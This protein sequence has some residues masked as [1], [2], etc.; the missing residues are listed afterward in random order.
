MCAKIN[1]LTI[2]WLL[3]RKKRFKKRFDDKIRKYRI[4]WQNEKFRGKKQF[5]EKK[6]ISQ[7]GKMKKE[8]GNDLTK[9]ETVMWPISLLRGRGEKRF[10]EK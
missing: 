6:K 5:D 8:V 1:N 10:D 7:C 4:V 2:F 9:K 3:G